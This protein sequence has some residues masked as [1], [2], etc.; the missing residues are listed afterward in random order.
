MCCF[1]NEIHSD[2]KDV[3]TAAATSMKTE[4]EKVR[5]FHFSEG[6]I[7][8]CAE[9]RNGFRFEAKPD[10]AAITRRMRTCTHFCAFS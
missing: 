5:Q 1:S 9:E 3:A 4:I 2:Y 10:M 6:I 7:E 8:T